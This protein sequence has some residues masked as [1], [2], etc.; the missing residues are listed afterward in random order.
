MTVTAV[1]PTEAG[2]QVGTFFVRSWGYDQT[3]IDF[4]K[5]VGLTAKGVKVQHWS[6]AIVDDNGP[7]THV[8]PG[9]GPAQVKDWCDDQDVLRG[10]GEC[11]AFSESQYGS[12]LHIYGSPYCAE[13][14]IHDEDAPVEQRR[15]QSYGPGSVYIAVG[16][17]FDH[18]YPWDGKPEYQTGA[19]WGH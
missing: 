18:A 7:A 1:A 13:H 19:G 8:V 17:Y 14:G 3:N 10:C 15:L 16:R 5:V 11:T 9:E 6:N 2:V 4:Y 12:T